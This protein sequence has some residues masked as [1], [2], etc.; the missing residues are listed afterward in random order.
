M[1]RILQKIILALIMTVMCISLSSVQVKA[2]DTVTVQVQGT[3]HQTEARKMLDMVNSF[4]TGN[5]T[6]Y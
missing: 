3:F 2:A 5:N 4:R 6:W 1:I